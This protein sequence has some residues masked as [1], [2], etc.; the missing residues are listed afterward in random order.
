MISKLKIYSFLFISI[1]ASHWVLASDHQSLAKNPELSKDAPHYGQDFK[2]SD[3]KVNQN[4]E[5][6]GGDNMKGDRD[7]QTAGP[8]ENKPYQ[9]NPIVYRRIEYSL[10]NRII[11]VWNDTNFPDTPVWD[12]IPALS[13]K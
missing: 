13:P 2:L 11:G 7:K 6:G 5:Q 4:S 8:Y 10:N 12:P 1:F 9:P 3:D